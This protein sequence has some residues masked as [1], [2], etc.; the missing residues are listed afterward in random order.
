MTTSKINNYFTKSPEKQPFK[1]KA[2]TKSSTTVQSGQKIRPNGSTPPIKSSEKDTS[3]SPKD[4]DHPKDNPSNSSE[5]P[6]KLPKALSQSSPT[7]SP[8][9]SPGQSTFNETRHESSPTAT[10]EEN[11]NQSPRELQGTNKR[12]QPSTRLE[13]PTDPPSPADTNIESGKATKKTGNTRNV[14]SSYH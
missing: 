1:R 6:I 11:I 3:S 12:N 4:Q 14:E 8:H 5:E 9:V 7:N 10:T 13:A 2:T